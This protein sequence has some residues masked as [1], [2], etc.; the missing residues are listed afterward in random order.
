MLPI[1]ALCCKDEL[2][3]SCIVGCPSAML[4]RLSRA[5]EAILS[6]SIIRLSTGTIATKA[7]EGGRKA[8]HWSH[9]A[10]LACACMSMAP[11]I[12]ARS[13]HVVSTY[14]RAGSS[15]P[16]YDRRV[17]WK[18]RLA[19]QGISRV[20]RLRLRERVFVSIPTGEARF[21][22]DRNRQDLELISGAG[23]KVVLRLKDHQLKEASH[24][25]L[26]HCV[27]EFLEA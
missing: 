18:L 4:V 13:C 17:L 6:S 27:L 2:K 8:L 9:W 12:L 15:L 3:E 23:H 10:Q 14:S 5:K 25:T 11:S 16:R 26:L 20:V 21:V 22:D 1:G 24:A 19:G 7:A